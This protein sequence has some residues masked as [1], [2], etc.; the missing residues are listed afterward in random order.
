MRRIREDEELADYLLVGRRTPLR[1]LEQAER[2]ACGRYSLRIP[3]YMRPA[4][5]D[6]THVTLREDQPVMLAMSEDLSL[7][8]VGFS[9]QEPLDSDY[10]IVQFDS[11]DGNAITLLLDVRWNNRKSGHWY[12]SGG[13]FVG[14]TRPIE[15]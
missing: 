12:L 5:F 1:M 14:V 9:H 7:R 2:R 3:F 15:M 6:G 13:R 11:L 10:A 8:G 4:D